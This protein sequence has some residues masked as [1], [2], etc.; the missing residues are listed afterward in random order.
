MFKLYTL[1]FYPSAF[2]R[3]HF[4][5]QVRVLSIVAPFT[6]TALGERPAHGMTYLR[7]SSTAFT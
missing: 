6:L 5:L 4:R 7:F 1:V 2:L 3:P